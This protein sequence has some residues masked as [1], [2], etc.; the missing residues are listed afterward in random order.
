M[1]KNKQKTLTFDVMD[2]KMF[3]LSAYLIL[4][5]PFFGSAQVCDD[6][7]DGDFTDNP[8]WVGSESLFII[9][10]DNQLQLNAESAGNAELFC[11]LDIAN[12]VADGNFEWRFWLK[13]AFSPSANN[14]CDIY[15]SDKYFVRF[16]E[17]GSNDVVDLQRVDGETAVS[18][19]RGTD[20]FIAASFS[21]FFKVTRDAEGLWK[22][23]VDKNGN[24]DYLIEAQGVDKTFEPSGNFGIKAVFSASNAK[25][26]YLDD[27]YAGPLVID[28]EPPC[29]NNLIVLKYNKIQLDFNEPLDETFALDA[30][31]FT[32]DNNIGSPMY[33]EYNGNNRSSLIL[34]FA[35]TIEEGVCYKLIINKIQDLSGNISQDV[36]CEFVHYEFHENDVLINEIMADPEPS[37]GLPSWE[38]IELYNTTEHPINIK[39]WVLVVGNS[40]KII[41][42]D[43]DIQSESFVIL[44]KEDA[45]PFLS[46]YGECVGFSSFSITN[47]GV[48]LV[49]KDN[50]LKVISSVD[51]AVSWYRDAS[52]ADGGWSLEQIDPHSPCLEAENWCA[53]CDPK[54]GTPGAVNSVDGDNIVYPDIDYVN[55]LSPNSIEIIFNQKMDMSSLKNSENYKI[56]EFDAN[57][58]EVIPSQDN[59]KSVTLLFQQVFLFHKFYKILVFGSTNCSGVPVLDGCDY[60]FG[61]PDEAVRGDVVINE[62]LFDP[63]SPAAD[64]VEIYNRSDKVLNIS[65][66]KLGMVRSSFP[67]P[68]D[69]T[70]KNICS[71]NRLLLPGEY[72]LLTTTPEVIA[73]QY[74][75]PT[76][77]FMQMESF[78]SYPNEGATVVLFH[79][80]EVIDFMSYS[81]DSHYPLLTVTKGVSLERVSPDINSEDLANWHSA[82]APLYGT[83]GYKNSVFVDENSE[84][85]DK[86]VIFP[87]VFSP[88]N[89]G[90]DDVTTINLTSYSSDYTAKVT[91]FDSRGGFINFLVLGQNIGHQ[92]LFV[93]DG[94]DENGNIVPVGIYIIYIELFDLQGVIER[95]KKTVVVAEK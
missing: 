36:D 94:T 90:F 2:A 29:L 19:C 43:I 73:A 14:F 67:N 74:E 26:I 77:R 80:S 49:L 33:V 31:N 39:D 58:Y 92:S 79:D 61:L 95:I 37:V 76:E 10:K 51:F 55:V 35:N 68:P 89:D 52:K 4:I 78:P 81:S 45:I 86:V 59:C 3:W 69:T 27:V 6:F 24:D 72:L 16:G 22:I 71:E 93:W 42:Q 75:C 63:I 57:P 62:I 60:A 8:R 5:M 30:D 41:T 48:G 47:A 13:E 7:S 21:A 9:N 17:A 40:E 18:V 53:S 38:F 70:I 32:V 66:L 46:E 34:S 85:T 64:Y 28:S 83:P 20:T 25:K 88:D 15:L 65:N 82:A 50:D 23:F 12:D 84:K 56:L 44:C 91:V 54:G 1:R 11:D 87:S